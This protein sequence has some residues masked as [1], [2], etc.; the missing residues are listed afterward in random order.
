MLFLSHTH[1]E[2]RALHKFGFYFVSF[3]HDSAL[4]EEIEE[5]VKIPFSKG[6]KCYFFLSRLILILVF[7]YFLFFGFP[8][9][10]FLSFFYSDKYQN[11]KINTNLINETSTT[12]NFPFKKKNVFLEK[13]ENRNKKT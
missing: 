3:S 9:H 4:E 11:K 13:E 7:E 12:M 10:N 1:F 5:N 8:S 2:E 6:N